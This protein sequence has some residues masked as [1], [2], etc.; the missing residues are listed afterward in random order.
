MYNILVCDDDKEIVDAVQ[1]YL[2][3]EGYN[4]Y[5]AFD[6]EEALELVK[7]V[8]FHLLV[9]DIMMPKVDGL[10]VV[11]KIREFSNVPVIL[12]SARTEY[13]D[14]IL[15]LNVGA[16]DLNTRLFEG[17][18]KVLDGMSYN[19]Y[20]IKDKQNVLLDTIDKNVTKEWLNNLEKELDG[21][22]IDYLIV[23]HM[24]P[25]H[26]DNIELLAS[27]F[28]EMKIVGNLNTFNIS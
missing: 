2:E 3:A 22:K 5:K 12:L 28:P 20:L 21:E 25:D 24:E 17:Q 13:N 8:D 10:N 1:I 23:S 27:K 18:Y 16:D 6:G 19:S 14:K 7:K 11:K 26:A 15:G 9:V 4:V